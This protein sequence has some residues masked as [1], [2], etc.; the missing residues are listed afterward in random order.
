MSSRKKRV[1]KTYID[2]IDK[3]LFFDKKQIKDP[4]TRMSANLWI[5]FGIDYTEKNNEE[6]KYGNVTDYTWSTKAKI[7]FYTIHKRLIKKMRSMKQFCWFVLQIEPRDEN[8][9]DGMEVEDIVF[10]KKKKTKMEKYKLVNE[11]V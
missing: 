4:V 6:G 10:S 3:S 2:D 11:S 1:I 7:K 5:Q 9:K 8:C